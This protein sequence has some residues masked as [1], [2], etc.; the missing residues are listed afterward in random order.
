MPSAIPRNNEN[1]PRVT[2]SAGIRKREIR[3]ALSAPPATPARSARNAARA[4]GACQS[5]HAA[6]KTTA[7]R[8]IIDPTERSIPP[9]TITGVR[10]SAS[11]PT[12][13]LVRISSK[14]F[15]RVKKFAAIAENTS[16]SASSARARDH[17]PFGNLGNQ[18]LSEAGS[19]TS[20][21][22][23]RGPRFQ[24]CGR[25]DDYSLQR[26]LPI[27][28]DAEECQ[29]R[30]DGAQQNHTEQCPGDAAAPAAYRR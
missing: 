24:T 4:G 8:P 9:D 7:A 20:S 18:R 11:N 25:Q 27:S 29:R 6:P 1:E 23:P 30:S 26:L 19:K 22:G 28:V 16:V 21:P 2:I 13:T 3:M 10:A 14:K 17:S 15:L 5:C 12:S